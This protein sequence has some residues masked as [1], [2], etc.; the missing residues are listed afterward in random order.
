[1]FF[2]AVLAV[3]ICPWNSADFLFKSEIISAML[4]NILALMMAPIVM[5]QATKAT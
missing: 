2:M 3:S 1:M 5:K 4:P